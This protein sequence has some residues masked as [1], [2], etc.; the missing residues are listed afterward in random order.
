MIL[1]IINI[2]GI[3]LLYMKSVMKKTRLRKLKP[4]N[5]NCIMQLIHFAQNLNN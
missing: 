2:N 3:E 1:L 4:Q 5:C